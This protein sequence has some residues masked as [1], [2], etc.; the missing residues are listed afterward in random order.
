MKNQLTDSEA[1][2]ILKRLQTTATPSVKLKKYVHDE[3]LSDHH[4]LFQY[5]KENIRYGHC[6]ACGR[7]FVLEISQM[8]KYSNDDILRLEAGHNAKVICPCCGKLVTKRYAGLSRKDMFADVA[9]F[10]VDKN[11][12]LVIYCYCFHYP[13]SQDY[14]TKTP[15]VECF[16]I[17]YFDLHKYTHILHGWFNDSAYTGDNYTSEIRFTNSNRIK[18]PYSHR[19]NKSEGIKCFGMAEAIKK[20]NLKYS[21]LID[22]IGQYNIMDMFKYLKFYCSYPGIAE[23]LVKQGYENVIRNY[24][25]YRILTGCFNFNASTVPA[26]FK[27]D[28]PHLKILKKERCI[29]RSEDIKAMQFI[30]CNN[31]NYEEE[32]FNFLTRN[33]DYKNSIQNLM[34]FMGFQKMMNY[35]RKQ[36]ILCTCDKGYSRESWYEQ[37]F[38]QN[39]KDYMKQCKELNYDLNSKAVSVPMNLVQS[40]QQLTNLLNQIE[41]EKKEAELALKMKDFSKRLKTLQ[42]KYTYSNSDFLIRPAEN[43]RELQKEGTQLHHCVYANY[44]ND[45]IAGKTNIFL[46]RKISEPD[47]PFY[48]LEYNNGTVIQCHGIYNCGTTPEL[49]KFIREWKLFIKRQYMKKDKEVA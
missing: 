14:R 27:L 42:K 26:F 39:Y 17:G 15:Q 13:F 33:C 43:L 41:A 12:A 4:I 28:K 22:Y 11:G 37:S 25:E 49:R 16:N 10:K 6:T 5:K 32:S 38:F 45:Y 48:T 3:L 9:E 30:Q 1:A 7:D 34:K 8:R 18:D 44:S 20:S 21:C 2:K 31:I 47:V 19:Q 40:H 29:T 35:V 36:G 24:L 23:K 46:I